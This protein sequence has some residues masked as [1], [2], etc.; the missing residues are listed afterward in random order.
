MLLTQAEV[1]ATVVASALKLDE[2]VEGWH[3]M[4]DVASLNMN[5]IHL[6]IIG[7]LHSKG[8]ASNFDAMSNVNGFYIHSDV[9]GLSSKLDRGR[10]EKLDFL[11]GCWVSEIAKRRAA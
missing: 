8:K 5:D 4:I 1:Q 9:E 11:A 6:C 7:Q 2:E 3:N 10:S